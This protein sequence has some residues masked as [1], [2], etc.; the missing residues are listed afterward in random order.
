M[1]GREGSGRGTGRGFF[2]SNRR[3]GRVSGSSVW[4][5]NSI[6]K[7]RASEPPKGL[8]SSGIIIGGV[9][10]SDVAVNDNNNACDANIITPIVDDL[11]VDKILRKPSDGAAENLRKPSGGSESNPVLSSDDDS[12]LNERNRTSTDLIPSPTSGQRWLGA[13]KSNANKEEWKGIKRTDKRV[14]L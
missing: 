9:D 14:S 12:S 1:R 10:G 6:M 4:N 11:S 2:G 3:G 7:Q 5:Q 13:D 8:S